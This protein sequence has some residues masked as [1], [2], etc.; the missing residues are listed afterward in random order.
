MIENNTQIKAVTIPTDV[1]SLSDA[2]LMKLTGQLDNTSQEGSV[3]SRLS[4]NY[5]TEDE[6]DNPLPR[7][8]FTL[9]V[10][11]DSVYAKTATFRPFMRM[12]AYSYWDNNEEV[13][14][15]SVQRPSLGDQ[16]PDSNGGYKCGKLSREQLEALAESDPQRV[17][18][19]SIKCNQVMYGV[20]D[21][22]GKKSDGKDVSL[23]Q[24][25]CVLYAKGV[26]YIPMSTTLKS[27]AT[28]KKPMIR[29]NLLLSTKKQKSGGNT[30]F[31]M[32]IKIGESVAMSEQDT[33]LLKEFA[34]VT[35]SVN[36]GV[37]EKHRTAVKQ[38][39]KDG[40]HSLAIELD[41]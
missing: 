19:S 27:L 7:G 21:M 4:I 37:M 23:K 25:P 40:D 11:G 33:V 20:A 30:F 15:S 35:K 2:E 28:Q 14:T 41:E 16:F 36:E 17:I 26:N 8:Q 12:F 10:D 24:I 32:D 18:Q 3:L 13:F 5:Q 1:S 39:T 6:N 22:E 9:K 34:A 29:N 38:Q 31:A